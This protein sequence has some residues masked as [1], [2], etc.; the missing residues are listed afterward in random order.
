MCTNSCLTFITLVTISVVLNQYFFTA[1]NRHHQN[2]CSR[3][4]QDPVPAN[5]CRK[6]K[7]NRQVHL[8]GLVQVV[9]QKDHLNVST[10]KVQ[11]QQGPASSKSSGTPSSAALLQSLIQSSHSA[12][13]QDPIAT[14]GKV[15]A[16]E[17]YVWMPSESQSPSTK[18]V[19]KL[20]KSTLLR[21]R[22]RRK[23]CIALPTTS[24]K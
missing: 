10:P 21:L 12:K 16:T 9:V 2:W 14:P 22:K 3:H 8:Q 7:I 19:R 20:A 17:K 18:M 23:Q 4:N 24:S 1:T 15:S 13:S 5:Q 11:M 6:V